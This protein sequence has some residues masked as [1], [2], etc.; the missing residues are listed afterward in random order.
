MSRANHRT[1]K[2]AKARA[3]AQQPRAANAGASAAA[4][5]IF[6][7]ESYRAYVLA[8]LG[9]HGKRSGARTQAALAMGCQLAYLSQILGGTADI[10]LEQAFRLSKFLNHGP[11]EREMLLLLVQRERAGESE[12]RAYFD[13][14]LRGLRDRR[15]L[16]KNRLRVKES[17]SP[18]DQ[19]IYY[20]RWLCGYLHVVVT[21]PGLQAVEPIAR[22]LGEPPEEV[23]ETLDFLQSRGLVVKG[24]DGLYRIGPQHL[25]LPDSSPNI[26]K[27]HANWRL[28]AL[29]SIDRKSRATEL[30]YSVAGSISRADA[31]AIRERFLKLIQ[32]NMKTFSASPEETIFCAVIDW[33]EIP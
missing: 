14:Q 2:Q 3:A 23:A 9:G 22:H 20:G 12:L 29:Q 21:I 13:A 6:A 5:D 24:D 17:L 27:H 32:D 19:A 33:F 1:A 4:T 18:D 10:S 31:A 25:H 30:H 28:K 11:D 7:F 8:A 16:I 15:L 26:R